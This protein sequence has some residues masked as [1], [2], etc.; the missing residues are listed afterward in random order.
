MSETFTAS[1]G[2]VIEDKMNGWVLIGGK[3]LSPAVNEALRELYAAQDA[4]VM[5]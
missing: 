1:N 3:L 4:R 5:A 2:K